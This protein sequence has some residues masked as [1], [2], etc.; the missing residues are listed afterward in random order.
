MRDCVLRRILK[1]L[2]GLISS[3]RKD[4]IVLQKI[5]VLNLCKKSN[6]IHLSSR[7]I[8]LFNFYGEILA[9]LTIYYEK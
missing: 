8:L 2:V 4:M 6:L 5:S 7:E 9:L 1:V 3:Q